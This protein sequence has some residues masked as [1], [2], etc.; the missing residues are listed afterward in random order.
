MHHGLLDLQ[1]PKP[2]PADTL[3]EPT[4]LMSSYIGQTQLT[5]KKFASC[6]ASTRA[7]FPRAGTGHSGIEEKLKTVSYIFTDGAPEA[8]RAA[9][10]VLGSMPGDKIWHVDRDWLHEL[11]IAIRGPLQAE[12]TLQDIRE[13]MI[14]GQGTPTK[15]VTYRPKTKQ[16]WQA[17]QQVLL[18]YEPHNCPLTT[19][20]SNLSYA[21]Q[22]A[23][24]ES[25]P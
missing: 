22:R 16:K 13:K 8:Q 12:P 2:S 21:P 19:V 11:R 6:N 17:L 15:H 3:D 4:V 25:T 20:L 23:D 7:N 24:S 14:T 1:V 18:K 9:R 10:L 5:F